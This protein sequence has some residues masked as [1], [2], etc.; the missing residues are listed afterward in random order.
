VLPGGSEAALRRRQP[1]VVYR[2]RRLGVGLALVVLVALGGLA[3]AGVRDLVAGPSA[4]FVPGPVAAEVPGSGASPLPGGASPGWAGQPVGRVHV[5]APGDTLWSI[6]ARLDPGG[7]PRPLV[8]ALADRAGG[9]EL[10][11]GQRIPLDGLV[12]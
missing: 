10:R 2:R 12:E 11:V 9:P 6:A 8:D 7:D 5:V 1:P 4:R 3:F